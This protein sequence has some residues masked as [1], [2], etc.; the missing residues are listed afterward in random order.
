[1]SSTTHARGH[2][3]G[4]HAISSIRDELAGFKQTVGEGVQDASA[5][6][7][8]VLQA[9]GSAARDVAGSAR[10]A[11]YQARDRTSRLI[12]ERPFTS[13]AIALGA[14]ALFMGAVMM[15]RGRR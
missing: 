12:A 5:S 10:D 3:D 9:A 8:R 11:A 14:G 1:M 4:S 13:V 15:L 6:G 7:K 2:L